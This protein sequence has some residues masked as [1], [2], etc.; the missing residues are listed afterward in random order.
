MTSEE[1]LGF[2]PKQSE[3]T[4]Q[5][6]TITPKIAQY[7]LDKHNNDNRDFYKTQFKALDKSLAKHGW[8]YDGSSM[9]F[10]TNGQLTEFQHRLDRIVYHDLT[11]S[12]P[13]LL[14]I[15]PEVQQKIAPPK[16]RTPVDAIFR[17][18]RSVV[19]DDESVL[20]QFL[21]RRGGEKLNMENAIDMWAMYK[22][23][24]L[25]GREIGKI[26]LKKRTSR[27]QPWKKE[28][29]GFCALMVS[30]KKEKVAR[31]LLEVLQAH[32]DGKETTLS[33]DFD[34]Y[35]KNEVTSGL[36]ISG[37]EKSNTRFIMLCAAADR[38][39]ESPDGMIELGLTR[40]KCVHEKMK[41]R[42]VGSVYREFLEDPDNNG[43]KAYTFN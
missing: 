4:C 23:N 17:K 2:N 9:S 11:V 29:Q 20:R 16:A 15:E 41:S 27:Y 5:M 36:D 32:I 30:I 37:P 43:T 40:E 19:K 18:D 42:V 25:K 33:R 8:C 13:V 34:K 28:I 6:V 22:P 10:N 12:V 1:V 3:Y 7:I 31:N 24:V 39:I 21:F 35:R 38:L 14:G 26:V